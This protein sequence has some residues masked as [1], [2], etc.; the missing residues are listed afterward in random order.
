MSQ[1]GG[2]DAFPSAEL[3][4]ERPGPVAAVGAGGGAQT[5][6]DDGPGGLQAHLLQRHAHLLEGTAG[7]IELGRQGDGSF[8]LEPT[9]TRTLFYP[10]VGQVDR[11]DE[12]NS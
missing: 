8:V 11:F 2:G 10:S 1:F 9:P 4:L 12:G 7:V 5:L 3:S 6:G